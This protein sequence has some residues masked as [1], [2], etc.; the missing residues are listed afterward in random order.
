MKEYH[1]HIILALYRSRKGGPCKSCPCSYVENGGWGAEGGFYL[2]NTWYCVFTKIDGE[3]REGKIG[4]KQGEQS[5]VS[6]SEGVSYRFAGHSFI[7]KKAL[8]ISR[9]KGRCGGAQELLVSPTGH[10][11][12]F[13]AALNLKKARSS[14]GWI[15]TQLLGDRTTLTMGGN[16]ADCWG[17]CLYSLSGSI[18]PLPGK[19][20]ERISETC[21]CGGKRCL[22]SK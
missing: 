12:F 19:G 20:E 22:L 18:A 5:L 1:S 13:Q 4:G 17:F 16:G 10:D 6:G 14:R 11:S 9:G 8:F 15:G 7:R 3:R 2:L 21:P